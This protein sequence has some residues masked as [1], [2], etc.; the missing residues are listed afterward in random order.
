MIINKKLIS[1]PSRMMV[2]RINKNIDTNSFY[3]WIRHRDNENVSENLKCNRE[4]NWKQVHMV[5]VD[6]TIYIFNN[7]HFLWMEKSLGVFRARDFG[8]GFWNSCKREFL[9][10]VCYIVWVSMLDTPTPLPLGMRSDL[11]PV[12]TLQQPLGTF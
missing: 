6:V 9:H 5:S 11:P 4:M 8:S 12:L 1:W 7:G 2:K 3:I 10:R